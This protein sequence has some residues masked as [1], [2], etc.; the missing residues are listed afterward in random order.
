MIFHPLRQMGGFTF[1][2]LLYI[3]PIGVLC[4]I[5]WLWLYLKE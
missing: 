1:D 2:E 4:A 3:A 5:L